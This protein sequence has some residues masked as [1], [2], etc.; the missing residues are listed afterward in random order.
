MEIN[1]PGSSAK[2][3]SFQFGPWMLPFF[4]ILI[5]VSM[6]STMFYQVG[7]DEVGVVQQFGKYVR[8]TSPGLRAKLP[9]GVETVQ[10]IK[11]THVFKEEFGFRTV[12]AGVRSIFSGR[13]DSGQ[14]TFRVSHTRSPGDG[15]DPFLGESLM[16]TGDLNAAV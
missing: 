15:N 7:P 11:V 10:K 14:E 4:G 13:P 5:A 1:Y 6:L 8:T 2:L 3:P 9:F 12:A 16:L